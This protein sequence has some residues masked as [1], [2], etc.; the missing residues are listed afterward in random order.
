MATDEY[1]RIGHV[2]KPHGTKGE[3]VLFLES[4][5][6]EW[7]AARDQLWVCAGSGMACWQVQSTRFAG[8]RLLV[9]VDALDSREAVEAARGTELFV[10]DDEARAAI[11][12]P[13]YFFNSDLVGLDL[14]EK[15]RHYGKV[16]NV[17]E[18]P[19]QNLLEVETEAGGTFLFPFVNALVDAIDLDAGTLWVKMPEGLMDVD[20]SGS[21]QHG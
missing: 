8:A 14:R 18:M 7:V 5:F 3:F 19:A 2:L 20:K 4:D 21:S 17:I 10:P 11:E 15:E 6:P 12:D 13:D 1:C 9:K 16:R